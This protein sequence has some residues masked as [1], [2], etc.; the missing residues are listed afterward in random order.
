ML[1]PVKYIGVKALWR[2]HVAGTGLAWAP[3]Q[4]HEVVLESAAR[5]LRMTEAFVQDSGEPVKAS[6]GPI[7]IGTLED[8]ERDGEIMEEPKVGMPSITTMTKPQLVDLAQRRFG[9]KLD[10]RQ[11]VAG[12][13]ASIVALENS[14]RHR[15]E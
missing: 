4:V 6:R 3:G 2:D 14:G 1:V 9:Q 12:L 5:L 15:G 8:R 10:A 7:K 13:R 11:S